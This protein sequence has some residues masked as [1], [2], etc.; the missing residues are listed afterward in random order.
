MPEVRQRL[1][2]PSGGSGLYCSLP[3]LERKGVAPLSRKEAQTEMPKPGQ[4][5]DHS[6]PARD[7]Q[8]ASTR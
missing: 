8:N 1:E 2:L 4:A 5:N 7:S 3:L 6:T